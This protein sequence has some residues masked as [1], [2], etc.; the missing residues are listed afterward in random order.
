MATKKTDRSPTG[1][2]TKKKSPATKAKGA[3]H[4]PARSSAAGRPRI[5]ASHAES[6]AGER[7]K[8]SAAE[9]AAR[10]ERVKSTVRSLGPRTP[11]APSKLPLPVPQPKARKRTIA[12]PSPSSA[13]RELAIAIASAGLEKKAIG[14]EVIDVSGRVDYAEYLVIMTGTSDRHVHSIALGIEESLKQKKHIPLG[15]EGLGSATWV[16]I[17]FDDVVVHVFQEDTRRLYDIEGLWIDAGRIEVDQ[18]TPAT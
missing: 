2:P 13:A 17:D 18:A 1:S 4:P 3:A 16:L 5:K 14:V 15:I 12:P 8:R 11:G 9:K 10:T 7:P 6:A